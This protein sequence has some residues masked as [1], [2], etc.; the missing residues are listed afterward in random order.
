MGNVLNKNRNQ[1][2]KGKRM[3]SFPNAYRSL[4]HTKHMEDIHTRLDII[5]NIQ[6]FG[7]GI[8]VL[9]GNLK[10]RLFSS[11]AAKLVVAVV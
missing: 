9:L 4:L 11:L 3:E 5:L 10:Q 1:T 6:S 7:Q 2:N 8:P